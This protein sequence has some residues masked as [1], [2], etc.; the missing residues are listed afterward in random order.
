MTEATYQSGIVSRTGGR[1][2]VA[3]R[4]KFTRQPLDSR[5][6]VRTA[7]LH[8]LQLLL[9]LADLGR[10]S[11]NLLGRALDLLFQLQN[12]LILLRD[13]DVRL[14]HPVLVLETDIQALFRLRSDLFQLCTECG[15]FVLA[16]FGEGLC[17]IFLSG[18]GRGGG[19]DTSV[20][21]LDT[22]LGLEGAINL[23]VHTHFCGSSGFFGLIDLS[24]KLGPIC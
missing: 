15:E 22:F 13:L 19:S 7:L 18:N 10:R 1:R 5:V 11:L 9:E 20:E 16:R 14:F 23:T 6:L 4:S 21:V 24:L 2:R 3:F 17:G 12:L 8:L